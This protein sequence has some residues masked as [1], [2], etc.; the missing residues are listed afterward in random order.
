M[1]Q[2][3][4]QKLPSNILKSWHKE[5][6]LRKF[7]TIDEKYLSEEP[8]PE[9]T[10]DESQDSVV[11]D[12]D[13]IDINKLYSSSLTVFKIPGKNHRPTW[14]NPMEG[15]K[16]VLLWWKRNQSQ[17]PVLVKMTRDFLSISATSVSA[18]MLRI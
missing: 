11:S 7:E 17:F 18:E 16:D 10:V 12:E 2:N 1:I 9:L 5:Q 3:I 15:D 13:L 14:V 4:K 6:I 8:E